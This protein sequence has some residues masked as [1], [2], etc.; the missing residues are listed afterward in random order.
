MQ[1]YYLC[2]AKQSPHSI[3]TYDSVSINYPTP[4]LFGLLPLYCTGVELYHRT[5][6]NNKNVLLKMLTCFAICYTF[7]N[8]INYLK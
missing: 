7:I 4:I 3:I 1:S 6:F 8:T 5:M 2:Q